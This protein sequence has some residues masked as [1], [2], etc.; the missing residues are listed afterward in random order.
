MQPPYA[1]TIS[2]T[3]DLAALWGT[4]MGE[5]GFASRTVWLAVLDDSG[6]PSPVLV[7]VEGVPRV[8]TTSDVKTFGR[9]LAGIADLG[10]AVMLIS[11]P[12]DD[13]VSEDDRCWGRALTSLAPRWPIHLATRGRDGRSQIQVI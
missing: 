10:T 13:H 1:P 8:P 7:P 5:G 6:R 9:A 2:T 3:E 4:L 12:G 11:P